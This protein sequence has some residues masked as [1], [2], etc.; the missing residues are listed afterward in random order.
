MISIKLKHFRNYSLVSILTAV[1]IATIF[2][3]DPHLFYYKRVIYV[4][5]LYFTLFQLFIFNHSKS[6]KRLHVRMPSFYPKYLT[7]FF[8]FIVINLIVDYFNPK[9]N[10]ITLLNHPL[11]LMAVVPVFAFK[12]GFQTEDTEKV[13]KILYYITIG[14]VIFFIFPIKGNNIYNASLACYAAVLPFFIFTLIQKQ[15]RVY[16]IGLIALGFLLSSA[17]DIRTIILRSLIF[18]VL[19]VSLN[20]FKKYSSLKVLIVMVMCFFLY[21]MLAN[22]QNFIDFFIA[23][24]GAKKFDDSDTRTFLYEEI[25]SDMKTYEL[26]IGRGFMGHY[27]SPYFLDQ[28]KMG[29]TDGDSFERFS[30]EVGFLQ[31]ILKGGFL[32]YF[33]YIT[34][35]VISCYKGLRMRFYNKLSFSISIII[36]TELLI[37]FIENIPVFGFQF[38]LL[39]FL[40]GLSYRQMSIVENQ[41]ILNQDNDYSPNTFSLS[42]SSI[43]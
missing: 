1:L 27:F 29:L 36:L 8:V 34:P 4:I 30:I 42:N 19:F 7:I 20:M 2:F 24:S 12:I 15:Y 22:L 26:F 9:F 41:G 17:S 39:F 35:L 37:M 21:E 13:F 33:L 23:D 38:F 6:E 11:G 43:S 31:L 18:C 25:F 32:Y 14:F 40:A 5:F 16:A 28:M 10:L 3:D